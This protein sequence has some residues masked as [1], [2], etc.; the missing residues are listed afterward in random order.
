MHQHFEQVH[1]I[2]TTFENSNICSICSAPFANQDI[3]QHHI[4]YVHEGKKKPFMVWFMCLTCLA[5]R[6]S[7]QAG[8]LTGLLTGLSMGLLR[9]S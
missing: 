2:T 5:N 3:L 8:L 9:G 4:K 1:G 7:Q 6:V